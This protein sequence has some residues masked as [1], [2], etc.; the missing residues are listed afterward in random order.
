M[1]E[2]L[3]NLGSSDKHSVV[4]LLDESLNDTCLTHVSL[5]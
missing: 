2:E 5:L 1:N 3:D 4:D